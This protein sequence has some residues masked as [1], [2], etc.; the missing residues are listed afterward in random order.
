MCLATLDNKCKGFL[1]VSRAGAGRGPGWGCRGRL[2]PSSRRAGGRA[3]PGRA[4]LRGR[5]GRAALSATSPAGTSQV[6]PGPG[7]AAPGR[8]GGRRG[9][10]FSLCPSCRR[11]GAAVRGLLRAAA[12]QQ[13]SGRR[14]SMPGAPASGCVGPGRCRNPGPRPAPGGSGGGCGSRDMGRV[15]LGHSTG[16]A[17]AVREGGR[18]TNQPPHP[19]ITASMTNREAGPLPPGRPPT[20]LR[21]ALLDSVRGVALAPSC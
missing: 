1:R 14:G 11:E 10:D 7:R 12:L 20:A 13:A 8:A 15:G 18:A 16:R 21:T 19:L 2:P 4:W 5:R 6:P 17:C 3:A 9:P